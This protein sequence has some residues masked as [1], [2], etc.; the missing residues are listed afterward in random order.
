[1]AKTKVL[2]RKPLTFSEKTYIPQIASG[3]AATFVNMFK[4]VSHSR[5]PRGASCDS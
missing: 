2:E 1:M 5:I 4:K 3:L